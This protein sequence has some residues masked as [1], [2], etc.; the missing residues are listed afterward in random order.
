MQTHSLW[1][2]SLHITPI[3]R[4]RQSIFDARNSTIIKNKEKFISP[5]IFGSDYKWFEQQQQEIFTKCLTDT[6]IVFN[7]LYEEKG[8]Y[9]IDED[10]FLS[11]IKDKTGFV[12]FAILT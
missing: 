12:T 9:L 6:I 1:E 3:C 7:T 2:R 10:E 8:V 5:L 4:T 11:E